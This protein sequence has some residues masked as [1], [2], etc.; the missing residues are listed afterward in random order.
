[1]SLQGQRTTNVTPAQKA[2]RSAKRPVILFGQWQLTK[3]DQQG[4]QAFEW[5]SLRRGD[6]YTESLPARCVIHHEQT[7]G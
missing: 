2:S 6:L 5:N 1:M 4:V 7:V 3:I